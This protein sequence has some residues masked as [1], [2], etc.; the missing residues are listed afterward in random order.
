LPGANADV[1]LLLKVEES[2]IGVSADALAISSEPEGCSA[3]DRLLGDPHV[4]EPSL[5]GYRFREPFQA[6]WKAEVGRWLL[7]AEQLG[8][9]QPLVTLIQKRVLREAADPKVK[10]ANDSAHLYL[11]QELA[12]AMTVYCLTR[13]GWTFVEWEPKLPPG[14]A[15]DVDMRLRCPL[16][17]LTDIQ[18]KAPDQ[19][20][21]RSGGRVVD[22]E[23]DDRICKALDK[24]L[25][26][27]HR[28]PGPQRMVVISPQRLW[29]TDEL[30]LSAHLVGRT[31]GRASGVTL[32]ASDRGV[33]AYEPGVQVGAVMRLSLSRGI[34]EKRYRSTVFLNPWAPAGVSPAVAAFR[35]ARV[36]Y[37][38]GDEFC[39]VP[40]P[41]Q[42]AGFLPP[43]T[44]YIA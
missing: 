6:D 37:L 2:A 23:Y 8:F 11:G 16:G 41:P 34:S 39:W 4:W 31:I 27:I 3:V 32:K 9:V 20:G 42:T 19:P 38:C 28:A 10:G 18:V 14:T 15:G 21:E 35:N 30:R 7:H 29:H 1:I 22:G 17:N 44:R 13:S 33:F 5:I 12:A 24:G 36:C 43:G 26:Q 40:E 25:M